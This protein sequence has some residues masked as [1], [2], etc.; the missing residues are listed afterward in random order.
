[1]RELV[2][3]KVLSASYKVKH[4]SFTKVP[5]DVIMVAPGPAVVTGGVGGVVVELPARELN[6]TLCANARARV[7]LQS[8][9]SLKLYQGAII[10]YEGCV[11]IIVCVTNSAGGQLLAF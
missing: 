1:M 7:V 11:C 6:G 9:L 5:R 4:S 3:N 2:R 10:I 8:S